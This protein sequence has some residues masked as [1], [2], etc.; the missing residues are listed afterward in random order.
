MYIAMNEN[1]IVLSKENDSRLEQLE[2][3]LL[4]N[5][6]SHKTLIQTTGK[7][8]QWLGALFEKLCKEQ[9]ADARLLSAVGRK[10]RSWNERCAIT[11]LE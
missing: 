10:A 1:L 3:F 7:I 6:Y 8:R 5:F 11:S 4:E 9:R 2:K